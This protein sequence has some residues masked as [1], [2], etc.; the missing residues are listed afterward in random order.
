[1]TKPQSELDPGLAALITP[2]TGRITEAVRA[3]GNM[4]DWTGTITNSGGARVFVK[5]MRTGRHA[6]RT[7]QMRRE[8]AVNPF[9]AHLAPPL[10]WRAEDYGWI[11]LGFE[12][13]D[14]R[15]ANFKP[16]SEDLP[17]V[18]DAVD[19]IGR[20]PL[21][22][23]VRGW[24]ENRWD[25]FT[26]RPGL[27]EGDVLAHADL[28]PGN[29][30][31]GP[32]GRIWVVDW[33]WPVRDAGVTDLGSMVMQ[34]VSAGWPAA[35]A[36]NWMSRCAAWRATSGEALD[37][38][39]RGCLRMYATFERRDPAEWRTAMTAAA[40]KWARHRGQALPGSA[41]GNRK[42]KYPLLR[43]FSRVPPADQLSYSAPPRM[44]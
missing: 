37:E 43:H 20:I 3:D 10:V 30:L 12:H 21:P 34:L 36:E 13:V 6:G 1:M 19:R 4:S 22:P 16:G 31:V 7:E 40:R 44:F 39:A 41:R 24:P 18:V 11:A 32:G 33:S 14:G 38:Y 15:H 28:H 8:E 23:P 35:D 17:A 27:F 26:D 9:L 42:M 5:A 2:N 25:K 29:I